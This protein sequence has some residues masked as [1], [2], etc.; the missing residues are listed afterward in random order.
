MCCNSV[1]SSAISC[2]AIVSSLSASMFSSIGVMRTNIAPLFACLLTT[3]ATGSFNGNIYGDIVSDPSLIGN[4]KFS[5]SSFIVKNKFI[6]PVYNRFNNYGKI[7]AT[8]SFYGKP[9]TNFHNMPISF[10]GR[11]AYAVSASYA[12]T[13]SY[14]I[15]SQ[16]E[17]NSFPVFNHEDVTGPGTWSLQIQKPENSIWY[18]FDIFITTYLIQDD[19]GGVTTANFYFDEVNEENNI[20]KLYYQYPVPNP[21]GSRYR[22]I[23][24]DINNNIATA[25]GNSG[26]WHPV[27]VDADVISDYWWSKGIFPDKYKNDDTIRI[28]FV[29]FMRNARSILNDPPHKFNIIARYYYP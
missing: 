11:T 21:A 14:I 5:G 10:N 28:Y 2:S 13:A 3:N 18:N 8:G 22:P 16:T 7:K 29:W 24:F 9:Y 1:G 15:N 20:N 25:V 12:T 6:G 23:R 19:A 27:N 26:Y 4:G 17:D